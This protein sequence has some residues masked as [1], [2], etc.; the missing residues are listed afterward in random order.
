[1]GVT[2]FTARH[3]LTVNW[4]S[5]YNCQPS[6][7]QR[8]LIRHSHERLVS[9]ASTVCTVG[10]ALSMC[11]ARSNRAS[12]RP[13]EMTGTCNQ[14]LPLPNHGQSTAAH[15]VHCCPLLPPTGPLRCIDWPASS[16]QQQAMDSG[17]SR[18]WTVAAA[19]GGGVLTIRLD[20][21]PYLGLHLHPQPS[22]ARA[23]S[24]TWSG[25]TWRD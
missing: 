23:D 2:S 24:I 8:C 13:C 18:Q 19:A 11:T 12:T 25:T 15:I 7:W 4:P 16:Q 5:S 20:C 9:P 21:G 14:F 10:T 3:C 6:S 22:I 17:S 1:M